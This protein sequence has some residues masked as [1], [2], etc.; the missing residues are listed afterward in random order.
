[1]ERLDK[2]LKIKIKSTT[3]WADSLHTIVY[4]HLAIIMLQIGINRCLASHPHKFLKF[5]V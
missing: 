2:G 1:M 3:A 4:T 5:S